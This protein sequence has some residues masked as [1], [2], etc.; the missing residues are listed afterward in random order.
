MATITIVD[1]LRGDSSPR[2]SCCRM[3]CPAGGSGD[4]HAGPSSDRFPGVWSLTVTVDGADSEDVFAGA[5]GDGTVRSEPAG[6]S[7]SGRCGEAR[8]G[9]ACASTV[10]K[11]VVRP[12]RACRGSRGVDSRNNPCR[13]QADQVVA[14]WSRARGVSLRTTLAT[15][16]STGRVDAMYVAQPTQVVGGPCPLNGRVVSGWGGSL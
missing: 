4:S 15:R 7:G 11:A 10:S 13:R 14:P 9:G 16:S 6:G 3:F 8:T 12:S 5:T 2:D 1:E